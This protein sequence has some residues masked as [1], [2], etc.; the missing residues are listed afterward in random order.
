MKF[1]SVFNIT[2]TFLLLLAVFFIHSCTKD[3]SSNLIDLTPQFTVD[4]TDLDFNNV[5]LNQVS[6]R[7]SF[8]I[9]ATNLTNELIVTSSE[10]QFEISRDG[11]IYTNTLSFTATNANIDDK[12][13][14]VRFA[15]NN[16]NLG[17]IEG[18]VTI[19]SVDAGTETISVTGNS[20]LATETVTNVQTF[21]NS[22]HGFGNGLSQTRTG[23]FEF[24]F[25][26]TQVSKITMYVQL[27]CPGEGCNAWDV[28][29]NIAVKNPLNA[30]WM[31]IGRYITPYGVDNHQ[32]ERGFEIDVTDFKS[33]LSGT[34]EL[35]SFVEVWGADGWNVS[36][37]FDVTTGGDIA[38][39]YYA[40]AEILQYNRHSLDG[41][42]YGVPNNFDVDKT[43]TIPDN[44]EVTN[45]RTIITGWGH[46]TPND[47]GGR[48]CAEWCFRIHQVLINGTTGFVHDMNAIGCGSNP[49]QPQGGNWAP[50]R[51]GWCPGMAVPNRIDSFTTSMAGETFT[52]EYD[53]EDWTSD[54]GG[55]SNAYYAISNFVVVKSNTPI[56]TPIVTE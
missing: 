42:P 36:V 12:L 4:V 52:F 45:L 11:A 40:I 55:T 22:R 47:P 18:T 39:P 50:D 32:L 9:D 46:A 56:E 5:V 54:S 51:A 34:V 10:A 33:M 29:A 8:V 35:K 53:L 14:Y 15:P 24:P 21:Q 28:F 27:E 41:I 1:R 38:Y 17:T 30:S 3:E 49:V 7:Q 26:M 37:D 23:S 31:E 25:D 44:A 2:S 20:V 16:Q 13:I 19:S 6:T 48:P 43:V